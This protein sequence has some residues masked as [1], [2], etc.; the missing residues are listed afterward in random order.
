MAFLRKL[1]EISQK[2][3][4]E[5][6]CK[7]NETCKTA[8]GSSG[9][10]EEKSPVKGG[11]VKNIAIFT[12]A[13]DLDSN[14]DTRIVLEDEKEIEQE[15]LKTAETKEEEAYAEVKE[16]KALIEVKEEKNKAQMKEKVKTFDMKID[17]FKEE[18]E[19]KD[20]I[21]F[22]A[23]SDKENNAGDSPGDDHGVSNAVSTITQFFSKEK[24]DEN[25]VIVAESL[26]SLKEKSLGYGFG[27]MSS[28]QNYSDALKTYS[29]SIKDSCGSLQSCNGC[30]DMF[31]DEYQLRVGKNRKGSPVEILS[32]NNL[33]N[34][35]LPNPQTGRT[36]G[37]RYNPERDV[38]CS[39][40][41]LNDDHSVGDMSAITMQTILKDELRRQQP[42]VDLT[43]ENCDDDVN[44]TDDMSFDAAVETL[45]ALS[46]E[47][48]IPFKDLMNGQGLQEVAR[49]HRNT[50]DKVNIRT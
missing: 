10:F 31:H 46:V 13:D 12:E 24:I 27:S 16:D 32:A 42:V 29:A 38:T 33:Q 3:V 49:R 11:K 44:G 30:S 39:D 4:E 8:E 7:S 6:E 1:K 34:Q 22:E 43:K 20:V 19:E 28:I 41:I 18:D 14:G 40:I 35:G 15:E 36:R 50:G 48:G 45:R 2:H 47:M 23:K 5:V 21:I 9:S 17:T 25:I 37:S 26:S